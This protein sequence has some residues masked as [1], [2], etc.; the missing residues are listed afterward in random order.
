MVSSFLLLLCPSTTAAAERAHSPAISTTVQYQFSFKPHLFLATPVR[1]IHSSEYRRRFQLNISAFQ[2]ARA[3][4]RCWNRREYRPPHVEPMWD[5]SLLKYIL[6]Y[7]GKPPGAL[8]RKKKGAR[9]FLLLVYPL[10]LGWSNTNAAQTF[11]TSEA[12]CDTKKANFSN[13][14]FILKI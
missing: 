3:A 12:L 8:A 2:H 6:R 9:F 10:L 5:N 7:S 1:V 4:L 11:F 14:Y 13:K